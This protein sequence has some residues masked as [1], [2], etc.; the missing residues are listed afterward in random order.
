MTRPKY[1]LDYTQCTIEELQ[2]FIKARTGR[3]ADPDRPRT[4]YISVLRALNEN[5]TFRFFDLAPELRN[6]V[7]LL[8]SI[9][10]HAA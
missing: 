7:S 3:P 10:D 2:T 5:A 9:C 6:L 4:G 1:A 8:A